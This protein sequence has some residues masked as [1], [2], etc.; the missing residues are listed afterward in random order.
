[1]GKKNEE[2]SS[3]GTSTSG[4]TDKK[5]QESKK[6]ETSNKSSNI[7]EI[8]LEEWK[9]IDKELENA[10]RMW[11]SFEVEGMKK[12][13]TKERADKFED[14]LN[15]LTTAIEKRNIID[16]YDYGSQSMSNLGPMYDLYRD[17][18]RGE[19][20]RIKHAAYQSYLRAAQG[21]IEESVVLLNGTEEYI[22]IIRQKVGT[23]NAKIKSLDKVALSIGDM[24]NSLKDNSIKLFRI[25]RD[26][27]IKNLEDLEK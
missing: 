22:N 9:K 17:E 1:M 20:G 5:D 3:E 10:H 6:G 2:K 19:I 7:D 27:I 16:I 11:N 15:F 4:G 13:V 8:L 18:I 14:N 24:K 21:R 26:I 12:G 25:K 23:N